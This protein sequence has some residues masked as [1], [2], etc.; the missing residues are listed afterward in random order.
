[1]TDEKS[2]EEFRA[3]LNAVMLKHGPLC[4]ADLDP[5]AWA[6][7]AALYE[8]ADWSPG[9]EYHTEYRDARAVAAAMQSEVDEARE[10]AKL[11]LFLLR[12]MPVGLD[13][14]DERLSDENLPE[15]AR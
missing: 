1:M 3:E 13:E 11:A 4:P 12:E 10:L 15:W 2:V 9:P 6:T 7:V 8:D 5:R 14:L